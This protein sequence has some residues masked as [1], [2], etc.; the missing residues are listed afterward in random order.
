[1]KSDLLHCL[2]WNASKKGKHKAIEY[3]KKT[4]EK[5]NKK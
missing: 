2:T 4:R 5:M 3:E 1:M